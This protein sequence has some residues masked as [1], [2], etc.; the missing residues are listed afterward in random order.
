M[1]STALIING[2]SP[3]F[4]HGSVTINITIDSTTSEAQNMITRTPMV[5]DQP[6]YLEV[7]LADKRKY[8][9]HRGKD[10][11]YQISR[12]PK[13]RV[14]IINN[15]FRGRRNERAGSAKDQCDMVDLWDKIGCQVTKISDLTA[16]KLLDKVKEFAS[17]KEEA[18]F[19]VL[20]VMSHGKKDDLVIGSKMAEV[21]VEKIVEIMVK[22]EA[23]KGKPKLIFFQICRGEKIEYDRA[24]ATPNL[25]DENGLPPRDGNNQD[26][27]RPTEG[28]AAGFDTS[29][30][31]WVMSL[32]NGV[33]DHG[34]ILGS[35]CD[36]ADDNATEYIS[37]TPDVLLAFATQPDHMS[38]RNETQGS[39]FIQCI[40]KVFS[41]D[42]A[43]DDVIKMM[44]KVQENVKT[45]TAY[46]PGYRYDCGKETVDA[47]HTFGKRLMLFP[48][49]PDSE[50]E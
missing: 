38:F 23:L 41:Q 14:L 36:K 19:Y 21:E 40:K 18:D 47:S 8:Y 48:G 26:V 2:G 31:T 11:F 28:G 17:S 15:E 35:S 16:S 46:A 50:P 32:I 49:F 22:R 4:H 30:N 27:V 29:Q 20:I 33:L 13:G 39:W 3:V 5:S 42:A 44:A 1:N 24:D 25:G 43:T 10:E 34:R 6:D 45:H 9:D 7:K 37:K 12:H